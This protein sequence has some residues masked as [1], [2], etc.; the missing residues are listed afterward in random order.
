PRRAHLRARVP[1]RSPSGH[2]RSGRRFSVRRHARRLHGARYATRSRLRGEMV[3]RRHLEGGVPMT[4]RQAPRLFPTAVVGSLPRP[5]FL[6]ELFDEFHEG[7]V[8]EAERQRLLD[9]AVPFALALQET[10]GVD[11]VSDGEWRRFSYVG[12]IT[13]V[14]SGF[15]RGLSGEKRD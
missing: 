6:K 13:D 10:A 12:V 15:T 2:D 7:K 8:N 4:K 5:L 1:Y 14:A 3:G 9:E 11:I